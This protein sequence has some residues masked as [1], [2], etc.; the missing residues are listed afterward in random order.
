MLQFNIDYN[1]NIFKMNKVIAEND[2]MVIE[3]HLDQ[4]LDSRTININ[5]TSSRASKDI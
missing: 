2:P 5:E 4:I 3:V 1:L